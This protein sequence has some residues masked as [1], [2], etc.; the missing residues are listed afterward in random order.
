MDVNKASS[1]LGSV[2]LFCGFIML[3]PLLFKFRH[4]YDGDSVVPDLMVIVSS[5]TILDYLLF[6][7]SLIFWFFG[8]VTLSIGIVLKPKGKIKTGNR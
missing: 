1:I 2:S 7:P 5:F 8:I 6:F 3:L 4:L